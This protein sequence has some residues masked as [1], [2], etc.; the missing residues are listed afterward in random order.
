M[1]KKVIATVW[2]TVVVLPVLGIFTEG[3]PT[4]LGVLG[5]CNG[6]P[7]LVNLFSLLYLIFIVV[8]RFPAPKW[9]RDTVNEMVSDEEECE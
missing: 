7:T 5:F 6:G 1:R 9:V 8:V 4:L 3:G 2:C